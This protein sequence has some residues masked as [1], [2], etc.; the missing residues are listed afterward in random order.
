MSDNNIAKEK[1]EEG[2]AD[3]VSHNY[4][5]SVD[6]LSQVI[7]LDPRFTLALKSRSGAYLNWIKFGRPLQ[8]LMQLLKLPLT[9]QEHSI[10]PDRLATSAC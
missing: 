5:R 2:M 7:E 10:S 8:I 4:G 3:F 9:M 1:F 6:L